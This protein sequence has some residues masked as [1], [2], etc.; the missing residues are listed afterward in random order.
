M[1]RDNVS[2]MVTALWSKKEKKLFGFVLCP[3]ENHFFFCVGGGRWCVVWFGP[4]VEIGDRE[5][6]GREDERRERKKGCGEK[7]IWELS[8]LT[9]AEKTE[10]WWKQKSREE[11]KDWQAQT[12]REWRLKWQRDKQA[13][14]RREWGDEKWT[15]A[16]KQEPEKRWKERRA[17]RLTSLAI[18]P[19]WIHPGEHR[20]TWLQIRAGGIKQTSGMNRNNP[21]KKKDKANMLIE[22]ECVCERGG[23]GRGCMFPRAGCQAGGSAVISAPLS[24][25]RTRPQGPLQRPNTKKSTN[26]QPHRKM[27]MNTLLDYEMIIRAEHTWKA[28]KVFAVIFKPLLVKVNQIKTHTQYDPHLPP[29]P[30]PVPVCGGFF[31]PVA[32]ISDPWLP[33]LTF[34]MWSLATWSCS[35]TGSSVRCLLGPSIISAGRHN[36]VALKLL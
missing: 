33:H 23:G 7:N 19:L 13:G 30:V 24:K 34:V 28:V 10:L 4:G 12:D 9:S 1:A 14:A 22:V 25:W 15:A 2:S 26:S 20:L 31:S 17:D 21:D 8:A 35:R 27:N 11:G 32:V 36:Q 6:W 18:R 29:V 3:C 16:M 5:M